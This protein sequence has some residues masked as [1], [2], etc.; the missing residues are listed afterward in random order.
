MVDAVLVHTGR[1]P[2]APRVAACSGRAL[3]SRDIG[4]GFRQPF[5]HSSRSHFHRQKWPFVPTFQVR[6][7]RKKSKSAAE[8]FVI[9]GKH[10]SPR[11]FQKCADHGCLM[12]RCLNALSARTPRHPDRGPS[13]FS[14]FFVSN[15]IF[16]HFGAGRWRGDRRE[17]S[18][19]FQ[20]FVYR[21]PAPALV[22]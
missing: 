1:S 19:F 17:F 10:S 16:L 8:G 21:P 3:C 11:A 15:C 12:T 22:R 9:E 18:R 7:G 14:I 5:R 13:L 20:N 4:E 2:P 6:R